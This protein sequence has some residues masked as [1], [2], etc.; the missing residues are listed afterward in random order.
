VATTDAVMAAAQMTGA[1][2]SLA[3]I[4]SS[5]Q[6]GATMAC[7]PLFKAVWAENAYFTDI[8]NNFLHIC[9]FLP[10]F[11]GRSKFWGTF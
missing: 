3:A 7:S 11:F 1:I 8:Y 5:C 4:V 6:N 2:V 10:I 9:N